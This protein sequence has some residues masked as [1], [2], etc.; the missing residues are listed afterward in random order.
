MLDQKM[1]VGNH[2]LEPRIHG[3]S[4]DFVKRNMIEEQFDCQR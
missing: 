1:L 4:G 2:G 3:E